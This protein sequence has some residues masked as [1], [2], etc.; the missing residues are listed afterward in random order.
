MM[1]A[2]TASKRVEMKIIR[3]VSML[4]L[5]SNLVRLILVVWAILSFALN[6]SFLTS[7]EASVR[8]KKGSFKVTILHQQKVRKA[9]AAKHNAHPNSTKRDFHHQPT[10]IPCR[11]VIENR[12]DYHYEILE[13]IALRYPWEEFRACSPP[14][15][16]DFALVQRH[17]QPVYFNERRGWEDYFHKQLQNQT[18]QRRTNGAIHYN[19]LV[20][21]K[22][23]NYPKGYYSAVISATCDDI[24]SFNYRKWLL[25]SP[26]N[27][28]VFHATTTRHITQFLNRS[29]WLNPMHAP[30]C[31]FLPLDL[32][33]FQQSK[34][35]S[36]NPNVNICVLGSSSK[37]R[38][39]GLLAEA[40]ATL[41]SMNVRVIIYARSSK[42][43]DKSTETKKILQ[44][45]SAYQQWNVSDIVTI[46]DENL[47]LDFQKSIA[48]GCHLFLPL[49][50][51]AF[52]H[53]YFPGESS[54]KRLTGAIVQIIA[55]SIPSIVHADLE[56]IYHD[57]LPYTDDDIQVYNDTASFIKSLDQMLRIQRRRRSNA[58]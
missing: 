17:K 56:R 32:P 58:G 2:S 9:E 12:V 25:A 27:Y 14:V 15:Q 6:F 37:D 51:T 24:S 43:Q 40:L 16:V 23:F 21:Y 55:N 41:A 45:T 54:L 8:S 3:H 7:S 57:Y 18:V 29:C 10:K 34:I 42:N 48:T 47:F 13:S 5:K 35:P 31:F 1:T 53:N 39:H 20:R 44:M 50:D 11:I 38:H 49:I 30:N 46:A 52:H 4:M 19:Q 28:C 22:F 33:V 36:T 26:K